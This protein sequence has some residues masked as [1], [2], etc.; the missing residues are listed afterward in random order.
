[1]RWI[2]GYIEC[3]VTQGHLERFM[4]LCRHHGIELWNVQEKER[5]ATFCMYAAMYHQ[6]KPLAR[7]TK[8][9]PHIRKKHGFPFVCIKARRNWT[10]T[11]GIGLFFITLYILSQFVW[12]IEFKGQQTY[13]KEGLGA[14]VEEMGIYR[15]MARKH[16]QCDKIEQ[17]LRLQHPDLSWVSAEEKG[18][19]LQIQVKE[20]KMREEEKEAKQIYSL[21]A[22]CAGKIDAIVTRSG[23]ALCKKGDV[24]KKGQVLIRGSYD[25]VGDDEQLIRRQGVAAEGEIRLLHT[26]KWEDVLQKEYIEKQMTGK[27]RNIY[28]FQYNDSR[29]SLKNPLKWFDN[30]ANYD[31]INYVCFEERFIPLQWHVKIIRRQFLEYD[32]VK[33]QYSKEQAAGVFKKHL[34]TK[35]EEIENKGYEVLEHTEK[36]VQEEKQYKITGEIKTCIQTMDKKKVSEEEL[37]V[38]PGKEE[39]DGT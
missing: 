39:T 7:K 36:M 13:T 33:K 38:A 10:F 12:S 6:V 15:G 25:V 16:L 34:M 1:M 5:Q 31:I 17:N 27:K 21:T 19:V 3:Q 9:V 22:P 24:V 29:I 20:G 11:W 23:T 37:A 26:I 32:K 14:E 4:N 35:M 28:T 2:M 30:S 18:C 8:T